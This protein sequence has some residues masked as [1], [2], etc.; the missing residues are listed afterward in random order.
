MY[1]DDGGAESAAPLGGAVRR[2]NLEGLIPLVLLV[3]I[4]IASLNY[5][6][7]IDVPFLPK[8]SSHM[9]VLV[10]GAPSAGEKVVLDNLAYML[11]YRVREASTFGNAASEELHQYDI[12]ILDQ[13]EMDKSVS[14]AL[15][16]AIQNYVNKGGKLIV[17]LNSGIYQNVGLM[18]LVSTD[19]IGWKATFG[20]IMPQDCVLGSDMVPTCHESRALTAVGRI[21]RQDY[22]HPIMAGIELTPP[23]GERPYS[24]KTF[25][26]QADEGAKTIAYIKAENTPKTYPAILE[27]KRFPLGG[28]VIYFNYDAG[29][30]PGVLTNTIKYLK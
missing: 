17:V 26:I 13:S 15:G 8:G 22:D 28:T 29:K 21:Y 5:F 23:A 19:V 4:G 14:V 30:T 25:A 6:G 16:E 9:Q 20:N 3:I 18:G 11:N 10:I 1:P 7:V 2:F 12:V 24:M 27:K